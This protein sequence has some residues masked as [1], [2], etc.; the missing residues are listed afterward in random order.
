MGSTKASHSESGLE[1]WDSVV[2]CVDLAPPH[3]SFS[4]GKF[5]GVKGLLGGIKVIAKRNSMACN[6]SS[7]AGSVLLGPRDT[8][9][10]GYILKGFSYQRRKWGYCAILFIWPSFQYSKQWHFLR[11]DLL[12]EPQTCFLKKDRENIA[13]VTGATGYMW[14][15]SRFTYLNWIYCLKFVIAIWGMGKIPFGVVQNEHTAAIFIPPPP[16][17][18]PT[19]S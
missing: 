4:A 3:L 11:K 8:P 17:T 5:K 13:V 12:M 2:N 14:H 16:P 1:R 19:G 6:T 18:P 9:G 7:G 10:V 15:L